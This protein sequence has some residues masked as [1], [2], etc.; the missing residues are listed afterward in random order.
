[1]LGLSSSRLVATVG[2][3]RDMKVTRGDEKPS[4][5]ERVLAELL[6]LRK[7]TRG[8]TVDSLAR[9]DTICQLLGSGDPYVAYTRLT[10]EVLESDLDVAIQAAAASLGFSSE[11]ESHLQR[12][13]EFGARVHLEQRQ[14][15][16]YSDTGIR[17]LARLIATNWPTETVPQLSVIVHRGASGWEVHLATRCLLVVEMRTPSVEVLIGSRR[18]RPMLRWRRADAGTWRRA[19]TNDPIQIAKSI[20]ETSIVFVWHGELWPKFSVGWN[21]HGPPVASESLGNKLMLRL[22]PR[23][24]LSSEFD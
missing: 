16:R 23:V 17:V 11:A 6:M 3:C 4:L 2:V 15:R 9:A 8:V 21:V 5:E 19:H 13:D 7:L 1:M 22:N 20:E 18:S 12:L 14:V 24:G 10:H